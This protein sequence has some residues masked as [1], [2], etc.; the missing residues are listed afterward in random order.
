MSPSLRCALLV[1]LGLASGCALRPR[2][3][4]L[5]PATATGTQL[6]LQL[7]DDATGA[8]LPNVKLELGEGKFRTQATTDAEGLF[9]LPVDKGYAAENAV[10]VV[11]LP[12]E[13]AAYKVVLPAEPP[14]PASFE[15]APV[16]AADAGPVP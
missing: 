11:T 2:Y 9:S 3:K 12:R 13:V 8:P 14:P 5:V 4:E 6:K 7:V 15:L 1:V 16:G 10:L